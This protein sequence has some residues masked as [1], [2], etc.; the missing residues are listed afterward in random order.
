MQQQKTV[1]QG[2]RQCERKEGRK[3]GRKED[4][5]LREEW[6]MEGGSVGES[7]EIGR[8]RDIRM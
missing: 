5:T 8:D 6:T 2:Q 7:A 4:G 3:E 1:S